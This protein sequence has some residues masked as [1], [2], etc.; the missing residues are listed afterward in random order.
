MFVLIRHISVS[1]NDQHAVGTL[2]ATGR[3]DVWYTKTG[4]RRTDAIKR[5]QSSQNVC[6]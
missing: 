6:C 1:N 4:N 5:V 3:F 2:P